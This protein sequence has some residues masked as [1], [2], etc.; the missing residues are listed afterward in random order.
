[1]L[2]AEIQTLRHQLNA[3]R[4]KSPKRLA[5]SNFDRLVFSS[6]YRIAPR[7]VT[8]LVIVKSAFRFASLCHGF[9]AIVA[10]P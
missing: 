8:A 9:S 6:L 2:E 7:V 10:A 4:R 1:L 5:F 3:L